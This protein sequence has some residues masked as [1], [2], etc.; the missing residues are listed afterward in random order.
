MGVGCIQALNSAWSRGGSQCVG[1]SRRWR[2]LDSALEPF[3]CCLHARGAI[4]LMAV[5]TLNEV[6]RD[7]QHLQNWDGEMTRRN[8]RS[9]AFHGFH[10]IALILP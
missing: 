3:E 4:W 9:L 2:C 6:L 5:Q 10:G 1:H 7:G 8:S